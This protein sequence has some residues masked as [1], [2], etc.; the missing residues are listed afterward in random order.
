MHLEAEFRRRLVEELPELLRLV[1][2]AAEANVLRVN[3]AD[4]AFGIELRRRFNLRQ[5][6][7][8]LQKSVQ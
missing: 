3:A 5:R 8:L 2:R 6:L 4:N 7:V 1:S